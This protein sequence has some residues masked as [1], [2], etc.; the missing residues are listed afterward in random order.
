MAASD[1]L[2]IVT[3]H[4]PP[5]MSVIGTDNGPV[6]QGFLADLFKE[7]LAARLNMRYEFYNLTQ[8]S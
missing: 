6:F 5:L 2:H 8:V 1:V 7:L 3:A 4:R